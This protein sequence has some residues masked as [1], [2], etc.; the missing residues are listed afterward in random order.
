M[1]NKFLY[2]VLLFPLCVFSQSNRSQRIINIIDQEIQEVTRL[3]RQFQGQNPN[4]LFRKSELYLEKGRLIKEQENNK[5]LSLSVEQRKSS[6]KDSHFRGSYNL[7]LKARD[8]AHALLKKFPD[9]E[10]AGDVYYILGFNEKEFGD[11][12]KALEYLIKAEQKSGN[13]PKSKVR[14]QNALA[15]M[16]YNNKKYKQAI[17]Y[18]EKN[19]S[20]KNDRWWTKDAYNLAW[21]HFRMRNYDPAIKYMKDVEKLSANKKYV[22]MTS[23]VNKD[24]GL[25]YA[26]SGR[27][28]EGVRHYGKYNKDFTLELITIATFLK[29]S[30]KFAQA[31][32]VLNEALKISKDNKSRAKI[33]LTR[34]Q[35]FD[36]YEKNNYHLKDSISLYKLTKNHKLTADQHKLFKFQVKKQIGKLQKKIGDKSYQ[37]SKV[38]TNEKVDQ[39]VK[40]LT[41]LK[42]LEPQT[43]NDNHFYM[44]ETYFQAGQY[45]K[46]IDN[47]KK[48]YAIAKKTNNKTTMNRSIEGMLQA[49]AQSKEKF[50]EREKYYYP[51]YMAYLK[52]DSSSNKAKEIYKK[53]YKI[54]YEKKN[55]TEMKKILGTFSKKYPNATADQEKMVNSLVNI[56]SKQGKDGDLAMLLADI[57]KGKYRMSSSGMKGLADVGQ[58][59]EVKKAEKYLAKKDFKS[60]K[61]SYLKIFST[62]SSKVAKANA[63]Y[64]LMVLN[65]EDKKLQETYTWGTQAISLM[66]DKEFSKYKGTFLSV[67]KYLF[68]RLQF[69]SSADISHRG[70][71]KLCKS[72]ASAKKSFY[73][74]SVSMYKASNQISNLIKLRNSAR[75]CRLDTKSITATDKEIIDYY[76]SKND[77]NGLERYFPKAEQSLDLQPY[78]IDPAF[79][80]YANYQKQRNTGK[81]K[82]WQSKIEQLYRSSKSRRLKVPAEGLNAVSMFDIAKLKD[83]LR[84][85]KAIRLNFPEDRFTSTLESKIKKLDALQGNVKQVQK[86]GAN[87][88]VAHSYPILIEGY[89]S[90]I[91]EIDGFT[92]PGKSP[93]YVASFKQSMGQVSAQLK[94]KVKNFQLLAQ[95]AVKDNEI[96]STYQGMKQTPVYN[97]FDDMKFYDAERTGR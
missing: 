70:Y 12:K 28:D 97:V 93:Q 50:P 13:N 5:Y 61:Q 96:L 36:K 74:N 29:E 73:N 91:S 81:L 2:L 15:E 8:E 72:S 68:E 30:G 57:K 49:V 33:Y 64:N 53:L 94:E 76:V 90:L 55:I 16:Y 31:T 44:A 88:G 35:L 4:I 1:K 48:G 14:I 60:A 59:I 32:T 41:L 82:Y 27:M 37:K 80:I 79:R 87:Y 63:A 75:T 77:Y 24:I 7:F 83:E 52:H 40:Y 6:S 86:M 42:G 78:L 56:Y 25:F 66:D 20:N 92:P 84:R 38:V 18:Y 62:G 11:D 26:E 95:K 17:N 69:K 23:Q 54:Q 71:A 46:A 47:Y 22:D 10:K 65:Y 43:K 3:S 45:G 51:V 67:S 21:S 9:Y 85:V 34:M 39:V 58:K 19:I 89:Q